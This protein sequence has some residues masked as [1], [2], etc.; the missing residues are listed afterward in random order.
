[1]SAGRFVFGFV[2][3]VTFCDGFVFGSVFLMRVLKSIAFS[4][5]VSVESVG[6]SFVVRFDGELYYASRFVVVS[7][8]VYVVQRGHAFVLRYSFRLRCT[9]PF[10]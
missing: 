1:M 4:V 3:R 7:F 8:I 9:T 5:S 2:L 10:R 6:L